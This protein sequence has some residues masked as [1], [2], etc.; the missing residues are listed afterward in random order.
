MFGVSDHIINPVF[1]VL[2]LSS[3][4]R[5]WSI[6]YLASLPWVVPDDLCPSSTWRPYLEQ[7]LE[8][9]VYPVLSVLTLSCSLRPWSIQY[10]A[11]SPWAAPGDPGPSSTQRLPCR[12]TRSGQTTSKSD[13][14][15]LNRHD[16][17][18][19]SKKLAYFDYSIETQVWIIVCAF[20]ITDNI[21]DYNSSYFFGNIANQ[22]LS[23]RQNVH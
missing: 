5:P 18:K 16:G 2:T 1:G 9:L 7:L 14:H 20:F 4:W 19:Q 8:T 22:F 13:D 10:S 21:K 23:V 6:Q 12:P 11:S 15:R 3:S 17:I